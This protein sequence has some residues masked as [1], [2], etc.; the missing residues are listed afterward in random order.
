M[1]MHVAFTILRG[2]A[3]Q[4]GYSPLCIGENYA[5]PRLRKVHFDV[6]RPRQKSLT[7]HRAVARSRTRKDASP[8]LVTPVP[9]LP[10]FTCELRVTTTP[11]RRIKASLSLRFHPPGPDRLSCTA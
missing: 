3:K 5:A 7:R 9:Y 1:G 11:R 6:S 8:E 10:T 2:S 4:L